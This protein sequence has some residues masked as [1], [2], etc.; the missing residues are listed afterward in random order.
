MERISP[1]EHLNTF[2]RSIS[3]FGVVFLIRSI[4]KFGVVSCMMPKKI[5]AL[6]G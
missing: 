5:F 6:R 1:S 3:K 2:I 4:S